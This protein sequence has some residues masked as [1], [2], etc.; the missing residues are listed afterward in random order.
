M[1]TKF[2]KTSKPS[3]RTQ[4][5]LIIDRDIDRSALETAIQ[6]AGHKNLTRFLNAQMRDLTINPQPQ[7]GGSEN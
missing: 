2:F 1:D 6:I 4:F 3:K 7:A 5:C